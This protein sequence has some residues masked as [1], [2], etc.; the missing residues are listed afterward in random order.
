[1]DNELKSSEFPEWLSI[2]YCRSVFEV[3]IFPNEI[4]V[5]ILSNGFHKD[6]NIFI[7]DFQSNIHRRSTKKRFDKNMSRILFC[8]KLNKTQLWVHDQ[9]NTKCLH[10]F[11]VISQII[12]I[13]NWFSAIVYRT[14]IS[15]YSTF[16]SN[17]FK[18]YYSNTEYE[19]RIR[20]EWTLVIFQ[21]LLVEF[22]IKNSIYIVV[23]ILWQNMKSTIKCKYLIFS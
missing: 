10:V 6:K 19:M 4:I 8:I 13:S 11:V 12:S 14:K 2:L 17:F 20:R 15:F 18:D 1:M 9:E 21:F 5:Q 22:T 3:I 23:L 7:F 16:Y